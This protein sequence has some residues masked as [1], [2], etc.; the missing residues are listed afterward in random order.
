MKKI[1]SL[2]FAVVFMFMFGSCDS[3]SSSSE[4]TEIILEA[5]KS[6]G[7]RLDT[8]YNIEMENI[9]F[10]GKQDFEDYLLWSGVPFGSEEHFAKNYIK[11]E[12]REVFTIMYDNQ[13]Q[14]IGKDF[15]YQSIDFDGIYHIKSVSKTNNIYAITIY[16]IKIVWYL[17]EV[18]SGD[19]NVAVPKVDSKEWLT[20]TVYSNNF[21]YKLKGE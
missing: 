18:K 15:I 21:E 1:I 3:A 14:D 4:K 16:Y 19:Y 10:D 13:R 2:I 11:Q 7:V 9:Y 12:G 20:Y 8:E 5:N 6:N 17:R